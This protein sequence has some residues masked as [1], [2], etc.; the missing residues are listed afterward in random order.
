MHIYTYT[1]AYT[2]ILKMAKQ[3]IIFNC[4]I[5]IMFSGL[6]WQVTDLSEGLFQITKTVLVKE[7][8]DNL[9]LTREYGYQN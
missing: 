4:L 5:F 9:Q 8:L 2:H 7:F 3:I 6:A 1:S